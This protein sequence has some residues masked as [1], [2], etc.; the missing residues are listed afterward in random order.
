MHYF[1]FDPGRAVEPILL[2]GKVLR[3]PLDPAIL[4]RLS[5]LLPE[6]DLPMLIDAE[7]RPARELN[8]F[9]SFLRSDGVSLASAGH[10]ARDL[11]IFARYLNDLHGKV[12]LDATDADVGAYR[13][14]RLDG[15]QARM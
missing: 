4:H 12:L 8:A 2:D 14:L 7:G 11:Q 13:R 1:Q 9:T 3:P 5:S 10:Y 6:T 15:R